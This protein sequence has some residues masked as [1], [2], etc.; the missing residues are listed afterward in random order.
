MY[1]G[2]LTWVVST[3]SQCS[4]G[5]DLQ[6]VSFTSV[7]VSP[8]SHP[9]LSAGHLSSGPTRTHLQLLWVAFVQ[10]VFGILER[11]IEMSVIS[12]FVTEL[13]LT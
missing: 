12:Y 4:L 1:C 6:M 9:S 8:A 13:E 5:M 2:V 11:N 7:Q 10:V 3:V